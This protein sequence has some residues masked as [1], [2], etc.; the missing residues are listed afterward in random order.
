MTVLPSQLGICYPFCNACMAESLPK[1]VGDEENVARVI[2]SPSYVYN[3][4]VA[5]TAFRW[6]VLP[7]GEAEDYI[8]VLRGDTANLEIETR[9]FKARVDGDQRYGYALLGVGR[10]REIGIGSVET[11]VDV[12]PF[13]SRKHP[14][15]AGIVVCIAKERV[16][17]LTPVSPEIMMV[18]KE[19]ALRCSEIVKF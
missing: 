3:G 8:S 4:R 15:H 11:E 18:Q 10:I 2:F 7:N 19:L 1:T 17:A 9:H 16:T 12:L 14:S 5:P 13:P 6:N